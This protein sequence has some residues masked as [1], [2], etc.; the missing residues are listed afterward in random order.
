MLPNEKCED[1]ARPTGLIAIVEVI[2]PRV[3]EVDR[4]LDQAEAQD[5][6]VEVQVVGR[7]SGNCGDVVKS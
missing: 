4:P 1:C 5:V 7:I 2:G 6:P 3:I